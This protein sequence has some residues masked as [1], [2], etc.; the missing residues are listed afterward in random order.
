MKHINLRLTDDTHARLKALA[1]AEHRSINNM[2]VV[3]IER[4]HVDQD[5][6]NSTL[7]LKDADSSDPVGG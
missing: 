1:D 3:L 4:T 7:V 2:I 5:R 6:P